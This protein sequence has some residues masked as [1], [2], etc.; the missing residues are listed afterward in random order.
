MTRNELARKIDHTILKA[1]ATY[2]E[3]RSTILYAR[4]IGAAS[5][6]LNPAYISLASGLLNESDTLV[7][8]VIGFPLGANSTYIKAKEAEH[9]Y[10]L[11]AREMDMV[12]NISAMKDGNH[13]YVKQDIAAVVAASPAPVKVILET[14]YLTDEEIAAACRLA[15]EAGAA[16]VKTSTGFG[17]SGA[18]AENV[19]LMRASV[20]ASVKVK[21]SGGI[22]TLDDVK[23]MLAAGADRLGMSRSASVLEA[24]DKENAADSSKKTTT[25]KKPAAKKATA[26]KS[27]AKKPAAKKDSAKPVATKSAE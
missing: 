26:K 21:A 17:P 20:S 4:E 23:T 27:T 8:T 1:N 15:E 19:A 7:C 3:I 9:A 18:T 14:C 16:F 12:L 10:Q 2:E 11:G 6:C 22:G 13:D 24:L 5:V 25:A